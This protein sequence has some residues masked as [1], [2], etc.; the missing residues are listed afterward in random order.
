MLIS[1]LANDD[2]III[3][4]RKQCLEAAMFFKEYLKRQLGQQDLLS[5]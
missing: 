2:A 5:I 3:E 4:S 1:K